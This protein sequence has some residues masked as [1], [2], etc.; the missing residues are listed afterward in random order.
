MLA[1]K[2]ILIIQTAFIGDAILASSLVE[3][4]H[5]YFP[6]AAV[7][8]LV[9]KGNESIY[10]EHPFLQETLV[11]NKKEGKLKNLFKLLGRIRKN[12]YDTVI[13]CHRYGSSGFLTAFSGARHTAG[14]KENPFSFAFNYTTRHVIGD[15]RHETE[16]YNALIED[17]TDTK[18]F[19]PKLYPS[20]KDYEFVKTFQEANYVCMAP[21]SVWY[22][23]Q[24]P[25]EKWVE[26]CNKTDASQ[27]IYLLG[28]PGDIALCENI[29]NK[30]SH[31]AIKIVAGQLSL[32]QSS[33]LMQS[34][35]MNYV[36][37]SGP[38]H[39]ASSL[40]A[41]VTAFFCSTVPEFGFG[42]LSDNKTIIEVKGLACKPCGLHG[43]KTCPLGHFKCGHE[44]VL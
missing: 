38:L 42:P 16:R 44:M 9:R 2:K 35:E 17:F 18:I 27:S 4:L 34:A 40:N 41:A 20:A 5:A 31:P 29:K 26:L 37:D 15:G 8:I 32:L 7:S 10:A 3:K 1:P 19:K 11:W 43:Y 24:L 33:A 30:S 23:K 13:N 21:A 39:L 6:Q 25:V 14:Y 22:T 36:N 28:A 12:N